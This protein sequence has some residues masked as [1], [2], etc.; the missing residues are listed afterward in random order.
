[1]SCRVGPEDRFGKVR[2]GEFIAGEMTR[3]EIDPEVVSKLPKSSR[4]LTNDQTMESHAS[5]PTRPSRR[6]TL[7]NR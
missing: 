2:D 5:P 4:D 3:E 6:R 7:P 1:M